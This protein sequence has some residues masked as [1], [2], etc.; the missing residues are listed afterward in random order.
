MFD[1]CLNV[2]YVELFKIVSL[3]LIRILLQVCRIVYLSNNTKCNA[4]ISLNN[5]IYICIQTVFNCCNYTVLRR[6]THPSVDFLITPA[7]LTVT[8]WAVDLFL[9][10]FSV[11]STSQPSFNRTIHIYLF[12]SNSALPTLVYSPENWCFVLVHSFH[13]RF[14]FWHIQKYIIN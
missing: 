12:I 3:S 9:P 1:V 8:S 7:G 5:I 4:G 11:L 13:I 6:S 10:L 14:F 2:H